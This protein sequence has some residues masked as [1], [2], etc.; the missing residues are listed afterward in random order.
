MH[1][2]LEE[3]KIQYLGNLIRNDNQQYEEIAQGWLNAKTN[4]FILM[5]LGHLRVGET[6]VLNSSPVVWKNTIRLNAVYF[7][8]TYNNYI[9]PFL[10]IYNY[11]NLVTCRKFKLHSAEN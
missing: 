3:L 1:A 8:R 7:A 6:I 2:Y 9:F 11:D 5:E 4:A 10:L